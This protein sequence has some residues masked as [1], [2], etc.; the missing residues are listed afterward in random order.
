[1]NT[2]QLLSRAEPGFQLDDEGNGLYSAHTDP[3]FWNQIGPFGGWLAAISMHAMRQRLPGDFLPRS[4]ACT[5]IDQVEPGEFRLKVSHV[6]RKRTLEVREVELSQEGRVCVTAQCVFGP[7]RDQPSLWPERPPDLQPPDGL[8]PLAFMQR[9]AKFVDRFEYRL[10]AGAAFGGDAPSKTSGYV[11]LKS[12][13]DRLEPEDLLLLADSWFPALWTQT[14][15]PVPATTVTMSAVFHG[16]GANPIP[17]N[18]FVQLQLSSSIIQNGYA[19]ETAE[20]W[21]PGGTL[22]LKAQQL[23]WLKFDRAHQTLDEVR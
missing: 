14:S 3:D 11:R 10:T 18:G 6:V 2:S 19:D 5:F 22:L 13:R 23:L 4:F 17:P 9:L 12:P 16:S 20:L 8:D 15:G 7:D 21:I 1:L